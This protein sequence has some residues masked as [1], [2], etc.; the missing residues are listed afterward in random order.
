MNK[1]SVKCITSL[2]LTLAERTKTKNVSHAISDVVI[3]QSSSRTKETCVRKPGPAIHAK[4]EW[5]SGCAE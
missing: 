4:H 3:F 1:Q 2:Q 5:L